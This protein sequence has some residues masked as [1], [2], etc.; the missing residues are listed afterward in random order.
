M[1]TYFVLHST[2]T[3]FARNY[4]T[5]MGKTLVNA[6]KWMIIILFIGDYI[7]V[8]CFYHTHYFSW[9]TVTHSHPFWPSNS[10]NPNHNHTSAQCQT[11]NFLSFLLL[12]FSVASVVICETVIVKRIY[13]RVHSY[14]SLF[15]PLFS[16]LRA[17]PV[18]ICK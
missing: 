3:I 8:T 13:V 16:P 5:V 14:N 17:P 9:G 12:T 10:E 1:C 18:F 4:Y 11:I 2:C 15:Q 6:G 7:S